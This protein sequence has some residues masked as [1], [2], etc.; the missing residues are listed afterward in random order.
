MTEVD[1][2]D[3]FS[4]RDA[5]DLADELNWTPMRLVPPEP[6]V[7]HIPFAFWLVKALRPQ[8]FV[9]LGTHSGNSYFA[10]CQAIATL[11]SAARA[12]AV[13]T[14]AGDE[15]A[16]Y[17]GEDV[18]A[19]VSRFNTEHFLQFSTLLRTSF[20]DARDYFPDGQVDLLHIDGL[21]SYEAVKHDF[22]RWQS[23]LSTRAV[24]L[25]HDINVREREFGVWRLWEELRQSYPHF[26]FIHSNGL[27]VLGVGENQ[28]P[29]LRQLFALSGDAETAASFRRLISSRGEAFQRQIAVHNLTLLLSQKDQHIENLT[30]Q[31]RVAA[32]RGEGFQR[33]IEARTAEQIHA[34]NDLADK[35]LAELRWRDVLLA[36]RGEVIAAKEALVALLSNLA[37]ARA[38]SLEARDAIIR[39]RDDLVR[40]LATELK[41]QRES[42][43]SQLSSASAQACNAAAEAN[44]AIQEAT[45]LA[46]R[47]RAEAQQTVDAIQSRIQQ[48]QNEAQQAVAAAHAQ[49]NATVRAYVTSTSWK[50]TRPLRVA[51]RFARSG[52][53]RPEPAAPTVSLPESRPVAAMVLPLSPP[54]PVPIE[55]AIQVDDVPAIPPLKAAMR[56]LLM[57]RLEAFLTS[58]EKLRFPQSAAP[59]V[60]ILLVLY[61][62]AELTFGCLGSIL[63]TLGAASFAFEVIIVDNHSTDLTQALLERIEGA[64]ILR[65]TANL[66]FL[67]AVNQGSK[68][69]R[70][71]TIL[72]LNND[73]QL[74]PGSVAS[75]LR[76]LDS[77]PNIGAV[78]G[79][80][81]LPDG[82]LQEAGSIV[83][84]D[85]A[86]SGYGRGQ[87]PTNP[88]FMFQRD[89]DYCSGAFLLTPR[90]VFEELGGFDERFSPAYYEET[91]YCMRLW[92][93]GRRV[94]F[95]P[96]VAIIHYEFGSSS[97]APEALALQ[98]SNHKIFLAQHRSWLE[99]QF[100]ASPANILAART[101]RSNAPRILVLED[102]VP[103]IELGTGY[104]RSNH[105]LHELVDAGAQVTL[106]PM[107]HH[108][109]TWLTVRNALDKR[110]EVLIRAEGA[111]IRA[112]LNARR[113]HFDAIIVCRPHNMEVLLE[114]VGSE[115]D[116]I[117]SAKLVYDAEALFVTRHLQK[118]AAEGN[119]P[120]DMDRHRLVAK[121]V[122][123]TRLADAVIS[124]A[125]AE[126]AVLEDYGVKQV[127]IL[128]H[129]LND[130]PLPTGFEERDQILFLGAIQ[131]DD[132]P[133]ADAVRWF[134]SDILPHVRR[135]LGDEFRLTVV[136]K[137][138]AST[139][140]A[141]D[142]AEIDLVGM[143]DDLVPA[144][145][146]A[147]V[148]VVP[149]RFAAGIP[150]KVHQAAMLGIPMVVTDLIFEQ[151]GWDRDSSVLVASESKAFAEACVRLY[152]DRILWE[153][154]RLKALER[155]R[156]DCAPEVFT[157]TINKILKEIPLT[158]RRPERAPA[159]EEAL[160]AGRRLIE[161][162]E[163]QTS[164]PAETDYSVVVPFGYL[165][166]RVSP[167]VAVMCHMFYP[168]LAKEVLYYL[169][170]IPTRADLLL[171]T[172]SEDKR[173]KLQH[174]FGEWDRG[175]IEIRVVP[176]RGR[177]IAPKL[178]G[179]ADRYDYDLVLHLHSKISDHA[180]FLSP[181]RG[182][183]FEN[184]AGSP[185]IISSIFDAFDR[186]P[187]LGMV[188]SQH[189]E[190]IRRWIG[191]NGNFEQAQ[192]LAKRMGMTLSRTRALDFPSGSMFWARP[193]ALRPL[194]DLNLS[195]ED[196]PEE[197]SQLDETPAHAIER[198]YFYVCERSGF[199][200][201][202][203]GQQALFMDTST[204]VAVPT[205]QALSRFVGERGV[206][207]SGPGEVPCRV[208][209][210]PMMTRVP[211]GLSQRL[212]ARVL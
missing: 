142:G 209:P 86:C 44:A 36:D 51:V 78:G 113:N 212:A 158:R 105:L 184:L 139:I 4:W 186:L 205:P 135:A 104:P 137:N 21:H 109:E 131:A 31:L 114:A 154:V 198:L 66:H 41:Q 150:H 206:M 65:N 98:A 152:K 45:Q 157:A 63:E 134:A 23:A 129:A 176:N 108:P 67:K 90:V 2:V 29:L 43:E 203:V 9:E 3:M 185:A 144:L 110:I 171:S 192:V 204:M 182:F 162:T 69:V 8:T 107:H 52:H 126:Q 196:F 34:S 89:V 59:D 156:L 82:T 70:G 119:S 168:E 191:W 181:W 155:A 91:D 167:R 73:A 183:L 197:G 74:L 50:V 76:T 16:G 7:G 96:D 201:L 175:D 179:F 106:F 95:D 177:D 87:D 125:P 38:A 13:D 200:W 103:K 49:L 143:V 166:R 37:A 6:W 53:L 35:Y 93:S 32:D 83:W 116:L 149:T 208:D 101:A 14:W 210:A 1:E 71:R 11:A 92:E 207:L 147:R 202:K 72:L 55:T 132:A 97:G 68:V 173:S 130:K 22:E 79:R 211:P 60:S 99:R 54:E 172:D 30:Q 94:V 146:R 40:K 47:A 27:G 24:V 26:E 117:G 165:P 193:A 128:G 33:E 88:D 112:Y 121:E 120:E 160:V 145:A 189:Y 5:L 75:A 161:R 124:V 133:N 170:N 127:Y 81:I 122:A 195:F 42:Y 28:A 100:P 17:Y 77:S 62:Q 148:L 58:S 164:R 163:P 111:Q 159:E 57:A 194:L 141:L 118:M 199:S 56:G 12:Y 180:R 64:T 178:V 174:I 10:F 153:S 169:R 138:Q 102:R 80:I 20:D 140:E 19:S 115:R 136:G 18:F 25:F 187:D 188:A 61:N 151:L 190:S 39:D 123:L 84:Q 46:A 15:H 85:G 48:M